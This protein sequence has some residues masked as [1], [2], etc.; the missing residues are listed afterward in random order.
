MRSLVCSAV[1][2]PNSSGDSGVARS[3]GRP[4]TVV[5]VAYDPVGAPWFIEEVGTEGIREVMV[6]MM[7]ESKVR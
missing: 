5:G 3:L 4:W 1:N 2:S 7:V 6:N